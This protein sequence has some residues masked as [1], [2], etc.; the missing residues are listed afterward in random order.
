VTTTDAQRVTGLRIRQTG[1]QPTDLDAA[2]VI[3]ASGRS[4]K[5]P[6]WLHH[7]GYEMPPVETVDVNIGYTTRTFKRR[8]HDLNGDVGAIIAP[9]PSH[10]KRVGFILAMEHER[11][12]VSIG[13]WLGN[14]APTDPQGF[15][16]FASTLS[17]PDIYDVIKD[18]E[19]LTDAVTYVFPSNQRRRY[20][21]LGRFPEGYLVAG[22]AVCSFNPVYGQGMSV[23][24]LEGLALDK[25]LSSQRA[26]AGFWQ[27]FFRSIARIIDTPWMIAAGSDFAFPGVIGP[28]AAGTDLVNWYLERVHRSAST[29]RV[30]CRAFFDVANLLKPATTLFHP[31]VVARV[32][33][34]CVWPS[35]PQQQIATTV[36]SEARRHAVRPT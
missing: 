6:E 5:S 12:I 22:D 3:D 13:G 24:A 28:K 33:K 9:H 18:A 31:T 10:Q 30:V 27:P 4:S 23:A 25:C 17:R 16:D 26:V 20:E 29:N 21:R 7:L 15:L 11:W 36:D 14:H 32:A 8:P 35:A 34:E 2:L 19:P 1:R